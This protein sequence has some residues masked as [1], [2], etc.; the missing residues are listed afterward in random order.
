MNMLAHILI[1]YLVFSLFL[2]ETQKFLLPIAIFAVILD[3]DH[4]PGYIKVRLMPKKKRKKLTGEDYCH[5]CRT[6]MQ[7]PLGILVIEVIFLVFYLYGVKSPLLFIAAASL[8]IH[9]LV[10]FLTVH[11]K[12]LEP[13]SSKIVC[14]FFSSIKQRKISEIIISAIAAVLFLIVYF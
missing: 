6:I 7:E 12:P 14:L 8:P 2:P 4:I 11:T 10:D 9:W 5:L 3:L 13:L 1:S